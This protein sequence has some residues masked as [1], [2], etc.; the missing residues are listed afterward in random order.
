MIVIDAHV[1]LWHQDDR[2]YPTRPWVQGNLPPHDGTAERLIPLMDQ[3]GVAAALNVQIPWYGPDN[4]YHHESAQKFHGRFALLGVLDPSLP[5]APERLERMGRLEGAQGMRIHFNEPGR[6][7]A[8]LEGVF[9]RLFES[10]GRNG[11]PIQFLAWM[12]DMAAI[13]RAAEAFPGTKFISDH[14]GHPDLSEKPPYRSASGF[15]ALARLPNVYVK[16]S[17]LCDHSRGEYP[18]PDVAEYVR[19][20][21]DAFG[22]ERLMWG[23]NFPLIPE[24]R[25]EQPVDYRRSLDL[26][27]AEWR[28]I[29][30][31]AME[32]IVGKTALSLWKFPGL[33]D[34][35][36]GKPSGKKDRG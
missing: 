14:L 16:V 33:A 22:P 27:R 10:A 3:A 26:V 19:R 20:T 8:V 5:D 24:V 13:A 15:F 31:R 34:R 32:W 12:A 29:D 6:R 17:K 4:R 21:I 28:W 11:A 7:E 9:D 35:A 30:A 18:Y 1:H 25:T 36:P 23:S 2:R